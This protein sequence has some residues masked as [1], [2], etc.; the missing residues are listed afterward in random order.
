MSDNPYEAPSADRKPERVGSYCR[1]GDAIVVTD[2]ARLPERCVF[3]NAEVDGPTAGKRITKKL[4]YVSPLVFLLILCNLVILAIVYFVTRKPVTISWSICAQHAARK[5]VYGFGCI[6][7]LIVFVM[8][9]VMVDRGPL[10][11]IGALV[12]IIAFLVLLVM[13]NRNIIPRKK[14]GNDFWI[15]GFGRD[16]LASI[17]PEGE[18]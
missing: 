2:G 18:A 6:G 7:A 3:C 8:S 16:F 9:L 11:G 10:F 15:K 4:Y 17:P 5:R 14:E 13:A 12:S 1:I